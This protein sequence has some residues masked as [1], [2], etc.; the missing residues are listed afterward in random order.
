MSDYYS[1]VA[2]I[3]GAATIQV[4]TVFGKARLDERDDP[5][6]PK[7]AHNFVEDMTNGLL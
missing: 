4:N 5:Y 3:W 7:S 1:R 6:N 2:T